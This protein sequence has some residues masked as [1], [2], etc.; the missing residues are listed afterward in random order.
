MAYVALSRVRSLVGL[1]LSAVGPHSITVST[2][3]LKEVNCL[4]ETFKSDLPLY[5]ILVK[6]TTRCSTRKRKLTGKNDCGNTPKKTKREK[7]ATK[8]DTAPSAKGTKHKQSEPADNHNT[9]RQHTDNGDDCVVTGFQPGQVHG[10]WPELRY[11]QVNEEW[12]RVICTFW[13][14]NLYNPILLRGEMRRLE[15]PIETSAK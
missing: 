3:C 6:P 9:K 15:H 5:D 12:Q 8:C 10:T 1:H 7:S 11:H 4:R 2:S 14:Y 13:V